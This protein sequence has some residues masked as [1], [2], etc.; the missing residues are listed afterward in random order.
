MSYVSNMDSR[1]AFE[2]AYVLLKVNKWNSYT[3]T[4][5]IFEL[6]LQTE[7]CKKDGFL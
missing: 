3:I 4:A 6:G 5:R 1:V 7:V 2:I